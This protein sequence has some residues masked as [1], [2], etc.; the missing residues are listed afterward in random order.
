MLT[1]D[2]DVQFDWQRELLSELAW[3]RA[4][5]HVTDEQAKKLREVV[6][7]VRPKDKAKKEFEALV[8]KFTPKKQVTSGIKDE[9]PVGFKEVSVK[10][11]SKEYEYGRDGNFH[12]IVDNRLYDEYLKDYLGS[13]GQSIET[14]IK[15]LKS[16]GYSEEEIQE[17]FNEGSTHYGKKYKLPRKV[18]FKNT[19]LKYKSMTDAGL[20]PEATASTKSKIPQSVAFAAARLVQKGKHEL[21]KELISIFK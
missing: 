17:L 7:K 1:S 4:R 2:K 3:H 20:K 6:K 19:V 10:V 14:A 8:Q 21:A 15:T 11:V 16:N 12:F 9:I 13:I 18:T 5:K